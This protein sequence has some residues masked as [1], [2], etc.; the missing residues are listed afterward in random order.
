MPAIVLGSDR[1]LAPGRFLWLRALGWGLAL[2][3]LV[4]LAGTAAALAVAWLGARL[5]GSQALITLSP[6]IPVGQIA[7]AAM[8]PATLAAYVGLVRFGER[9]PAL[10]LAWPPALRELAIGLA[11]GAAM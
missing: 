10:E 2:F 8:V 7:Y 11:I 6:A 3:V 4:L 1:V 9:R 5:T